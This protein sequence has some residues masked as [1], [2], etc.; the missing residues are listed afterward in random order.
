MHS[1][2]KTRNL[3]FALGLAL[4]SLPATLAAQAPQWKPYPF[5]ADGFTASFPS[6][7][8]V[9]KQTVNS[10]A[11]PL[12]I[13][14]YTAEDSGVA[15]IAAVCDYGAAAAGKDP[16]TLLDSA[17]QG[18]VGNVK[19]RLVSEKKITLDANHGVAFE[20]E[21]DSAHLSARIYLVGTTL[22]QLIVVAPLQTPYADSARFL[23]SLQLAPRSHTEAAAAPPPAADWKPYPYPADGFS[24]S[25]P[26]KPSFDKQNVATGTGT[27]E[28][29]SYTA[30]DAATALIAGV[31][32]FGPTLAGK[33]PDVIL[34]G[35]KN[36]AVTNSK[37]KLVSEKPITLG[38]SHGIEFVIDSD[39]A[40]V[41][42]RVYLVGTSIYEL[43]VASPLNSN[44]ADTTR[45]LDSLKLIDRVGK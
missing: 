26:S 22:Y 39:S 1:M 21:N 34:Q 27:A 37:G 15:L 17:K 12:E 16:D 45:F 10:D 9:E 33:D 43:I 24:A 19:G 11:G 41:T 29:H 25:F 44:Y 28:Y 35:A 8:E 31:T 3:R 18:A 5:L 38:A 42:A 30:E 13:R 20:A 40:R 7:P 6:K 2:L 23:D 36:G 32:D 4:L 14:T